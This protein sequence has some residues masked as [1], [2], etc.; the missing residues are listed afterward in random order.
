MHVFRAVWRR[1][2][3]SQLEGHAKVPRSHIEMVGSEEIKLG[4]WVGV[5]RTQYRTPSR[6]GDLSA[7]RIADIEASLAGNGAGR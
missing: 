6:R 4:V 1:C 3:S 7:D 5:K 2:A